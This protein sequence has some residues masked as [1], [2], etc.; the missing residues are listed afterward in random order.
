VRLINQVDQDSSDSRVE[1]T[2]NDGGGTKVGG[3]RASVD[4]CLPHMD[5]LTTRG[6]AAAANRADFNHKL[7]VDGFDSGS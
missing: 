4:I 7:M 5:R 6:A 3:V 1:L 2:K